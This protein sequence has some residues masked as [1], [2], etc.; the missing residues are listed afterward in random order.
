M[1]EKRKHHWAP[2]RCY[3]C[4]NP[5]VAGCD[6]VEHYNGTLVGDTP[7]ISMNDPDAVVWCDRMMCEDHATRMGMTTISGHVDSIDFC[8][9]HRLKEIHGIRPEI[10][11]K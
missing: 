7:R 1:K 3:Y 4:G 5:A 10:I 9:K 8:E 6:G 2:D 11:C